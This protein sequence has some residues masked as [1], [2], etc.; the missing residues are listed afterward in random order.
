MSNEKKQRDFLHWLTESSRRLLNYRDRLSY[1]LE[2]KSAFGPI[3][4][5]VNKFIVMPI[6]YRLKQQD[7]RQYV[8]SHDL[9]ASEWLIETEEYIFLNPTSVRACIYE[10]DRI[11]ANALRDDNIDK[12]RLLI[13]TVIDESVQIL[14]ADSIMSEGNDTSIT[15]ILSQQL[16]EKL[17]A[18]FYDTDLR[19]WLGRYK[20][21]SR[22]EENRQHKSR[23]DFVV[24]QIEQAVTNGLR[25]LLRQQSDA[26]FADTL[27]E[28]LK[29]FAPHYLPVFDEIM[30]A[31][32]REE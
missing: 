25:R 20:Q 16:I 22:A 1:R 24:W 23:E 15:Q 7:N 18:D 14:K 19:A 26:I 29:R 30:D 6:A 27:R 28:D 8:F 4:V 9:S 5:F 10:D 12:I 13:N 32:K 17:L 2:R 21:V 11:L 31:Q 3:L